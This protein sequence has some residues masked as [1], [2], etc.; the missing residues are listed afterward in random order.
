MNV[1]AVSSFYDIKRISGRPLKK[2]WCEAVNG[3]LILV[4]NSCSLGCSGNVCGD[5]LSTSNIVVYII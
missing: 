3:L 4:L 1:L 5:V 2:Y